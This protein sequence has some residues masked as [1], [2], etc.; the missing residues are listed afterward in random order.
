MTLRT[1]QS[2]VLSLQW[3]PCLGVIN[4]LLP[5][6]PNDNLEIATDVLGMAPDAILCRLGGIRHAGVIAAMVRQ[7]L[8]NF[9]MTVKALEQRPTECDRVA[10]GALRHGIE[11]LVRL[12]KGS[13]RQ[14]R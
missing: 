8:S 4:G 6:R 9:L 1:R 2:C 14:L 10:G 3:V 5:I 13:G 11:R 7:P 12:R